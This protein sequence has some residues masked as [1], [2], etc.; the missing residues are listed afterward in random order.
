MHPTHEL[1]KEI[2]L[3]DS[4]SNMSNQGWERLRI[5][6]KNMS[7]M[8]VYS[9]KAKDRLDSLL[10][11][12]LYNGWEEFEYDCKLEEKIKFL[13][14][15][16]KISSK[17]NFILETAER[18]GVVFAGRTFSFQS[19]RNKLKEILDSLNIGRLNNKNHKYGYRELH[20]LLMHFE[21]EIYTAKQENREEVSPMEIYK[22]WDAE[23]P[24][25]ATESDLE[26]E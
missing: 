16:A 20:I 11:A 6:A 4:P 7:E 14:N 1:W 3:C 13:Y 23:F 17:N 18:N 21:E 24:Y 8:N 9:I 26:E 22:E 5:I 12:L 2:S 15:I 19:F 25:T 10:E